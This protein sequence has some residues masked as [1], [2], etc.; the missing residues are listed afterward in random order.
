MFASFAT[1]LINSTS[2][3][4]VSR[5]LSRRV[6]CRRRLAMVLIMV[7]ACK[8]K[9]T[10]GA[11]APVTDKN[12]WR[13]IHSGRWSCAKGYSAGPGVSDSCYASPDYRIAAFEPVKP[14]NPHSV[15]GSP[16]PALT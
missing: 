1:G 6:Y 14:T 13:D 10:F 8:S 7:D 4:T 2:L 5:R 9:P 16:E 11:R 15:A 3:W 12:A